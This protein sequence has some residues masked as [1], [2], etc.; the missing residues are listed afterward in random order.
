MLWPC[1]SDATHVTHHVVDINSV[2]HKTGNLGSP[3]KSSGI[4]AV[5]TELV[6]MFSLFTLDHHDQTEQLQ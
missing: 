1:C 6:Y 4:N 5:L 3:D 2:P